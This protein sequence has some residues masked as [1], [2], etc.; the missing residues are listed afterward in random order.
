MTEATDTLRRLG[1][2]KYLLV[3]TFRR[4]GKPV[5]TP[6]WAARDGDALT[7]WTGAGSGKVKRIRN[8][9]DVLLAPCDVRGRATG[10]AVPG[11]A[12]I[13]DAGGTRRCRTLIARKYGLIGRLTLAGSR[14]RRGADGTVGLRITLTDA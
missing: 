3:T 13:L 11:R 8:R 7:V 12:K 1:E 14:L 10:D 9:A 4:S 6:V 5:P 2:G